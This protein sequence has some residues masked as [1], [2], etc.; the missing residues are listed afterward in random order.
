MGGPD[1]LV[2]VL[3]LLLALVFVRLGRD[4]GR[5]V[6]LP[7]IRPRHGLGRGGDTDRVRAHVGDKPRLAEIADGHAFIELLGHE[8]RLLHGEAQEAEAVLLEGAGDVGRPGVLVFRLD[9]D[10]VQDERPLACRRRRSRRASSALRTLAFLP[11]ILASGGLEGGRVLGLEPRGDRPVF[12]GDEGLDLLLPLA[13]EPQGHG[14]DAAG[15][16]ARADLLPEERADEIADEPVEDPAGL[17][18]V[19]IMFEIDLAE[20]LESRLDALFGDLV[21]GRPGRCSGCPPPGAGRGA[22]KWPRLPGRDRPPG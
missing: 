9:L 7:D 15:G 21:E 10:L 18:G 22:R 14:L 20:V 4:V 13:D 2:R 12:L 8:H 16:Q 1:G 6:A 5:R 19:E 11:S 17:L 3:G